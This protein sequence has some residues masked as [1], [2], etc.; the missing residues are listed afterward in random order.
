MKPALRGL[1]AGWTAL[2][3]ALPAMLLPA[4]VAK[5]AGAQQSQ[6]PR[7]VR[8]L[9]VRGNV[10]MIAGAG[11]NIAV[12][13]GPDGVVVVDSGNAES[14]DAVL[15]A[16][17]KLSNQP[18]RFVINTG[19]DGDHLGANDKLAQAG[20]SFFRGMA[21]N[22]GGAS[23]IG[24]ESLLLRISAPTGSQS[25]FP[26]A[27]WP[28][29]TFT[30]AKKSF[31]LNREGIEVIQAPGAHTDSDSMVFF[32]RSDVIVAGDVFDVTRFPVIDVDR[33][34]SIQGE[35]AALNHLLEIAIPSIPLP[36]LEDGGTRIVPGH[37]WIC[38]E[39]EVVEYRD[40]VTIIRDRIQDSITNGMTLAQIKASN[41]TNGYRKR[42]GSESGPWTTDMFVEAV[43]KSLTKKA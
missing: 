32:R 35:I 40:M 11:G 8:E 15:A 43:Y 3:F 36:Y 4:N 24:T 27:I 26:V 12:Q 23:I 39:A 14:A 20:Q 37:G 38:E 18:I 30:Q 2:F 1:T 16:I 17:R 34:G 13:V 10:H 6:A 7:G 42:Y 21:S 31:Y 22:Q 33:G 9:H 29:D 28:T 5:I 41:P 19:P 25:L